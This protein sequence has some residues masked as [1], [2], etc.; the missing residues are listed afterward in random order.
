[1]LRIQFLICSTCSTS[2]KYSSYSTTS[3]SRY[4]LVIQVTLGNCK[5]FYK[6]DTSLTAPPV[7]FHSVHGVRRSDT[8]NSEFQVI[9]SKSIQQSTCIIISFQRF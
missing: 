4:M 2:A 8:D 1:M 9:S 5:Q 6:F 3:G 7:G